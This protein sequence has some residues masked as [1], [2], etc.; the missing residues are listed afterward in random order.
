MTMTSKPSL[1]IAVI[2]FSGNVGKSTIAQYLLWPRLNDAELIAIESI[3]SDGGL[4]TQTLKGKQF[5]L[6]QEGLMLMESAVV[7]IGAS[8]V[9]DFMQLMG[10]YRG[11]HQDFDLFIVPVVP[12]AKQQRDT[13]GTIEA[14]ASLGIPAN[15]IRVVMNMV[16]QGDEPTSLFSGLIDY[17][18]T[19]RKFLFP[20]AAVLHKNEVYGKLREAG[21]S[22]GQ[23]LADTTD[24]LAAAK[25]AV[26]DEE[27]LEAVKRHSLYRLVTG[28]EDELD[29]VFD[30]VTR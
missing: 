28:V 18:E 21:L 17:Q 6:L 26:S 2:N 23:V 8:N 16:E 11:S 3:N 10:Q 27:R 25:A 24:Y 9:E 14:L 12:A 29:A 22:I 19:E 30:A 4:E 1:K 20:S 13:I 7:D 5:G 15:K